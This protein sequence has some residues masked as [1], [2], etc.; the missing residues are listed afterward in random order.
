MEKEVDSMELT[1]GSRVGIV[2]GGPAGSLA[3][4]FLLEMAGRI[5]LKLELD[6]YE[7]RDYTRPGPAGCNMCG[8]IVSESLVQLLAT[9]GINLP[10]SVVQRGID[11]YVMH[12]ER[13]KVHIT[14][15]LEEMRIAALHRG[16][17]PKGCQAGEWES[18]DG[19]LLKLAQENGANHIQARVTDIRI[20]DGRPLITARGH[21]A[22]SYDLVVG[23][24]GVN[25]GGLKLFKNLGA[26]L[27]E[28]KTT[29]TC[30]TEVYLG[31]EN[32][33]KYLKNSMHVFLLDIPRLEFACAIPKKDY[34]TVCLLGREVDRELLDRFMTSP[35]VKEL[36]PVEWEPGLPAC[37]CLPLI[38][39]GAHKPI[40]SDR[41]VLI[42]DCGASRL[43]KD[44]IGAA[45]RSAK[46]CA[47]TAVFHG[48]SAKDFR[49]YYW[50]V[51]RRMEL[52]NSI[53]KAMFLGAVFFRKLGFLRTAVV[54][55]AGNE[56]KIQGQ[57][58]PMSM[59]LWDMFTGSAP[60]KDVLMR[61][62]MP[63]FIFRFTLECLKALLL[64]KQR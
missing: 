10:H 17:G 39:I 59:I 23:A 7:P 28:P 63:G 14:T 41:I 33:Y 6:I 18:F 61:G 24:V 21:P 4:Y 32:V 58:R 22:R 8:G 38:N 45:Y 50:P 12:T 2:G 49:K 51:C 30:I 36:L 29:R 48:V 52:D 44:G 11:S 60:Y 37:R 9:E 47:V 3:G 16:S 1:D 26:R 40:F 64:P 20:E 57:P 27:Q 15:P 62:M 55:M 56:Q 25:S 43:Y 42:G 5:D 54:R 53:G 46:P 13:D 31:R 34:V 19:F 35:A